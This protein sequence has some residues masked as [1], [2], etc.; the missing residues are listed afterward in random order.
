VC[1]VEGCDAGHGDCNGVVA[2]GCETDA[3]ADTANCGGCQNRCSDQ[4]SAG[5]FVCQDMLCR[6][7]SDAQC[8]GAG[9]GTATCDLT[10][11]RCACEGVACRTGESCVKSGPDQ[12]CR[13]NGDAA[14][15][16]NQV[17]CDEPSG[18]TDLMSD[19]A[20]CGACGH[21][22]APGLGCRSGVCG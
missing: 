20:S 22:C 3:T 16:G 19:P 9:N 15:E 12:V 11:G 2:D 17:C 14:C 10:T 5:G 1:T 21:A 18:C 13:C 8:K 4:G 6:C 7:T